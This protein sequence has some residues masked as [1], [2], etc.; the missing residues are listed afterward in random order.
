MHSHELLTGLQVVTT[1]VDGNWAMF[2]KITT[3]RII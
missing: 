3:V 2:N 1:P